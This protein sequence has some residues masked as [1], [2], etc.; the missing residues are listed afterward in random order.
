MLQSIETVWHT[1][2]SGGVQLAASATSDLPRGKDRDRG[3]GNSQLHSYGVQSIVV[4]YFASG[5]R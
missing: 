2:P 5:R 3:G 1:Y 4:D